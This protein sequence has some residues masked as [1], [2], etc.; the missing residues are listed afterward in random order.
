MLN[1]LG[2]RLTE[3]LRDFHSWGNLSLTFCHQI[4]VSQWTGGRGCT[5]STSL[6]TGY[7]RPATTQNDPS[8]LVYTL[9][10][11]LIRLCVHSWRMEPAALPFGTGQPDSNG[12]YLFWST[13]LDGSEIRLLTKTW[14]AS[15]NLLVCSVFPSPFSCS[16]YELLFQ[17][18]VWSFSI[19]VI[20][21]KTRYCTMLIVDALVSTYFVQYIWLALTAIA[22]TLTYMSD[23]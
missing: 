17:W 15:P 8:S 10:G 2:S 11:I 12:Q 22:Q 20:N 16:A 23:G 7:F 4:E 3:E 9:F 1:K 19:N 21:C 18:Q 5:L 6:S 13:I 14:Y